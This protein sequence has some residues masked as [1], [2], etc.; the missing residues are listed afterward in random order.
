MENPLGSNLGL[1]LAV[2]SSNSPRRASLIQAANVTEIDITIPTQPLWTENDTQNFKSSP[3]SSMKNGTILAWLGHLNTLQR[4]VTFNT[5][6][7][8]P[9]DK[10]FRFLDSGYETALILEDD[11]DWDIRLRS[12]QIPLAA[13]AIRS[14]LPP[15]Y[16]AYYWGNPLG[17]D[18][19]YIGHCGDY[20]KPLS[21]G[22]G[23]GHIHPENLAEIPHVLFHDGSLPTRHDLHPFTA[24]FHSTF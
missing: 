1:V 17:W 2:S 5:F 23:V 6:L 7:L 18:L 3:Y 21:T 9:F 11:V 24:S 4:F 10:M 16:P 14:V 8:N 13:K 12:T 15:S 20:F 19:L 22:V